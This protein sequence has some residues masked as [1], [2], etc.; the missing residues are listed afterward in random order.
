M[1]G[2]APHSYWISEGNPDV[3]IPDIFQGQF[4][5]FLTIEILV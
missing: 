2:T 1:Y 5:A 3:G 4:P